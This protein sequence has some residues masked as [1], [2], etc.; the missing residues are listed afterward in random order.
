MD[1]TEVVNH[2]LKS[3]PAH[4]SVASLRQQGHLP[5]KIMGTGLIDYL[6]EGE[7]EQARVEARMTVLGY[8][9][10]LESPA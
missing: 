9:T 4:R 3:M 2:I 10:L 7:V 5:E 8:R 1:E 6:L